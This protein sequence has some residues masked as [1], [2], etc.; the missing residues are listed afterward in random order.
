MLEQTLNFS[1]GRKRAIRAR[2][3][4]LV[5]SLLLAQTLDAGPAATLALIHAALF[6]FGHKPAAAPQIL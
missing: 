1:D 6:A 4:S 3:G 2:L 5:F